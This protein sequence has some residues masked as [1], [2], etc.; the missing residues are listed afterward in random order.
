MKSILIHFNGNNLDTKST[1]L[2]LSMVYECVQQNLPQSTWQK[3]YEL[4]IY[5]AT[6]YYVNLTTVGNA[7]GAKV[8][9]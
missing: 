9:V 5:S 2:P 6:H 3:P 4:I 7:T 1:T 8:R